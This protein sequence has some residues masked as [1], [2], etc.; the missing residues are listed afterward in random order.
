MRAQNG[1][2]YV[3]K[4]FEWFTQDFARGG[5]PRGGGVA[6]FLRRYGPPGALPQEVKLRY[7]PYDWQLNGQ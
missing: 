1:A 3:S 5:L 6:A 2:I 7:L 4:I